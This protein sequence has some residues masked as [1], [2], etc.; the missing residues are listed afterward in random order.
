MLEETAEMGE[1]ITDSFESES[2][3]GLIEEVEIVDNS[4]SSSNVLTVG[5][6]VVL[7]L[8]HCLFI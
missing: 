5:W 4:G 1:I 3:G 6:S 7:Y 2:S 8:F